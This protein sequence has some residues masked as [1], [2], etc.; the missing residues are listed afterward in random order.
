MNATAWA[1][2]LAAPLALVAGLLTCFWGYRIL[3][4][5]LGITGFLVGMAAGSSLGL[6]MAPGNDTVALICGLV[7]G[8]IGAALC[9]WL[10]FLGVF[11]LGASTGAIVGAAICS[12]AAIQP[13]PIILIVVSIVFGLVA[14][15]LQKF[16]IILSTAFGGSYLITAGILHFITGVRDV[17]PP[18]FSHLQ[19]GS[20]GLLGYAALAFWIILGVSGV[21]FQYHGT[22][23]TDKAAPRETQVA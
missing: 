6:S 7:A 15:A 10:F 21:S 11:L 13:Q 23:P 17:S 16:M 5:T 22:K 9:V 20:A 1:G 14:L 19:P 12:A 8:V 2:Q 3:K 4:I 18:W